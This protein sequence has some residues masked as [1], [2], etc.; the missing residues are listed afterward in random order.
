M[1]VFVVVWK[2]AV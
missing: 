1:T 2:I